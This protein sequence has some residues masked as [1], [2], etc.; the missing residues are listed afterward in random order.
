MVPL[1]LRGNFPK[2]DSWNLL[3]W[4]GRFHPLLPGQ[5]ELKV[6]GPGI[7]NNHRSESTYAAHSRQLS[8]SKESDLAA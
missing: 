1:P 4:R 8:A 5:E 6:H 2:F 7:I 3:F